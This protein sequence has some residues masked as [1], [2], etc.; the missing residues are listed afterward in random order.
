MGYRYVWYY[1]EVNLTAYLQPGINR[2]AAQVLCVDAAAAIDQGRDN[3]SLIRLI[4]PDHRHRFALAAKTGDT[5]ISTGTADWRVWMDENTRLKTDKIIEFLGAY[6]EETDF[7]HVPAGWKT[8]DCA[9]WP[10][11]VLL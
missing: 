7:H 3:T 2:F 5:D 4:T 11:A 1:D 8:A 10:R 6:T 9:S